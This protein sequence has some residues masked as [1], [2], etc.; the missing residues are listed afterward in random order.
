MILFENQLH[1][2]TGTHYSL[3]WAIKIEV[4][5]I[6]GNIASMRLPSPIAVVHIGAAVF[7]T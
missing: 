2:E 6:P 1:D 7:Q 3:I 4:I 5:T